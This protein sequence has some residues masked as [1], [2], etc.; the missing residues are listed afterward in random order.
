MKLSWAGLV[1]LGCTVLCPGIA[2]ADSDACWQL[3][4]KTIERSAHG[5]HAAFTHYSEHGS[6]I[7]DGSV[8]Q[9]E[10]IDVLYRDDGLAVVDDS[11]W[12]HP[13]ISNSLEPGPPVLGPYGSRR[14]IW[15]ALDDT[16]L[17][18]PLIGD[19]H[20][21]PTTACNMRDE[22]YEGA[23]ATRIDLP[24]APKDRPVLKSLWLDPQTGAVRKCVV[25]GRLI[26]RSPGQNSAAEFAPFEV[27][28][29]QQGPY[30]VVRHVTWKY[31]LR[32]YSQTSSLFGEYYYNAYSFPQRVEATAFSMQQQRTP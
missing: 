7:Q 26:F 1:I 14:N 10:T 4:Y 30:T 19:V 12:A 9:R 22:Y 17:P 29:E 31:N 25:L 28:F 8:L 5:P 11:R 16:E 23:I 18:Y 27:E 32:Y 24:D 3:V 15:L 20:T 21:H 6:I 13:L 2:R